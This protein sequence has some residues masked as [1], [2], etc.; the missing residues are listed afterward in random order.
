MF[1]QRVFQASTHGGVG[2]EGQR[3]EQ[4]GQKEYDVDE[5]SRPRPDLTAQGFPAQ[6]SCAA[7]RGCNARPMLSGRS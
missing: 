4:R 5:R 1:T 2:R 3:V 6:D 7:L